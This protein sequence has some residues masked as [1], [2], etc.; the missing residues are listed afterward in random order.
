M[1]EYY[2]LRKCSVCG[3]ILAYDYPAAEYKNYSEFCDRWIKT[4]HHICLFENCSSCRMFTKLDL[5][6]FSNY[7]YQR[8]MSVEEYG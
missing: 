7:R 2:V 1:S 5:V 6:G 4:Y 3:S 8:L